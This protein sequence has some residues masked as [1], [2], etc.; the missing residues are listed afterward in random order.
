MTA[1]WFPVTIDFAPLGDGSIFPAFTH[2]DEIKADSIL[3]AL[4]ASLS[5]WC[6]VRYTIRDTG[7]SVVH[8]DDRPFPREGC[9]CLACAAARSREASR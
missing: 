4:D 7:E 2:D 1:R 9:A 3:S 8:Y 5:N 6:G